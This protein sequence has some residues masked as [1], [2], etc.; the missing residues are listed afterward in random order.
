MPL[1]ETT[2]ITHNKINNNNSKAKLIEDPKIIPITIILNKTKDNNLI[3]HKTKTKIISL[4]KIIIIS[5][6]NKEDHLNK[7][8]INKQVKKS[9]L[10]LLPSKVNLSKLTPYPY[11]L[12]CPI[13]QVANPKLST[14]HLNNNNLKI[15]E[16][17]NEFYLSKKII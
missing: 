17:K 5:I 13:D 4:P 1:I 16:L 3:N 14:D 2:V 7:H 8:K 12:I 15:N 6:T 9:K 10:S 11:Q